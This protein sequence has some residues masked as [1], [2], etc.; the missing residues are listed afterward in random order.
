MSD[1]WSRGRSSFTVIGFCFHFAFALW[2]R[3]SARWNKLCLHETLIKIFFQLK[4]KQSSFHFRYRNKL[5]MLA[6]VKLVMITRE[7]GCMS[8]L[9]LALCQ[10]KSLNWKAI[11][12]YNKL[13]SKP[14]NEAS[15]KINPDHNRN[16]FDNFPTH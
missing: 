16:E 13:V 3:N 14:E 4:L 11:T 1:R 7:L 8:S 15:W 10:I 2:N 12:R 9:T 5:Q 6:G